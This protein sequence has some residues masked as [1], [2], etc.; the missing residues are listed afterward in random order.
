MN[1]MGHAGWSR[2]EITMMNV[3]SHAAGFN[4]MYLLLRVLRAP[5]PGDVGV[6]ARDA[7][8]EATL[9]E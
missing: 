5:K 7:R 9:S 3:M 6:L 4:M 1:A 2:K 8:R